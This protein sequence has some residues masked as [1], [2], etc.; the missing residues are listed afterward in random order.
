MSDF[1]ER[2]ELG[3]TGMQTSRLGIGSTFDAPASVIEGAFDRGIN[4]LYWGSVRQPEFARA[5]VNLTRQHRDEL[6]LTVQS[7]SQDPSTIEGEVE[8]ALKTA[9]LENFDFLLLGNRMEVPADAYIEVFEQLR[10]RGKVRFVSLSSHNRPLLP[11]LLADYEQGASPY[12]LLMFRYNAVHR[13]AETDVFPFVPEQQR[14]FM[15]TYTATRWGHLLDADKMPP[16]E[17]PLSARDCYRYSLSH[18]A[19][20]MVICGPA[21]GE[22]M[23]EAISALERGPLEPDER[24]R[25][26]RIGAYI[27]GQYAPQYSDAGDSED[28]SAGRAAQ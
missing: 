8:E 1:L 21:N 7:Y 10:E 22:Q 13:G 17:K 6:I 19:V 2:R 12:E 26:E 27:Y 24:E 4:Y 9:G 11:T 15:A 20:D 23:N 14:P 18:A 3:Q 5:M 28:V 25:I 16:G